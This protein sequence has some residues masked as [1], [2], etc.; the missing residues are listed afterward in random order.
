MNISLTINTSFAQ[1]NAN[2]ICQIVLEFYLQV[3]MMIIIMSFSFVSQIYSYFSLVL[4]VFFACATLQRFS[5]FQQS[6][7]R[8]WTFRIEKYIFAFSYKILK[9][10]II[11]LFS[12]KWHGTPALIWNECIIH[13]S[14]CTKQHFVN[15]VCIIFR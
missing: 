15:G 11:C 7:V 14:W 12:F 1:E 6:F 9:L 8:N 10:K 5:T 3:W 4:H 13:I 2:T